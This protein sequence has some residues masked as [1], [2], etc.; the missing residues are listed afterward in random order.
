MTQITSKNAIINH[1]FSNSF[2]INIQ[3]NLNQNISL[4]DGKKR[5]DISREHVFVL[6]YENIGYLLQDLGSS[7]HTFIK[8]NDH[9]IIKLQKDLEIMMGDSFFK[10]Q[11]FSEK[12]IKI[13]VTLEYIEGKSEENIEIE[14][15]ADFD[16]IY[17]GSHPKLAMNKAIYM[18]NKD[19]TIFKENAIFRKHEDKFYLIALPSTQGLNK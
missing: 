13:A 5:S 19:P 8:I 18:F 2:T 9:S 12:S 4:I 16:D 6:Y 1:E 7:N 14:F 11:T 3:E 10:I 15:N 17:F